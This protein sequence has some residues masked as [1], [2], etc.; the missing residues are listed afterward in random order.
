MK[1]YMTQKQFL[2]LM[3]LIAVEWLDTVVYVKLQMRL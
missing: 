1:T 2:L 3:L